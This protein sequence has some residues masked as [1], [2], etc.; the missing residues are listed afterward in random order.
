MASEQKASMITSLK[1]SSYTNSITSMMDYSST[2]LLA[3]P[4]IS[5]SARLGS[6][7]ASVCEGLYFFSEQHSNSKFRV[8]DIRNQSDSLQPD[9]GG[10]NRRKHQRVR[11]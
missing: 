1:Q 5:M 10:A 6:G 2:Q 3:T 7:R 9:H 8:S 11:S 4:G